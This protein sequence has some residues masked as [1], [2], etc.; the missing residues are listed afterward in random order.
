MPAQC[1]FTLNGKSTWLLSCAG[2]GTVAAFSGNGAYVDKP[3]ATAVPNA[4]PFPKGRY[5]IIKREP[6]GRLGR[7]RDFSLD[8]WSNSDRATWFALYRVDGTIDDWTFVNG[9][10]R[11]NFRLHPNG[12][13]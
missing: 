7:L 3:T 8:M 1:V 9:V 11:G 2:F 13:S 6:G 12:R 5:Y 10:R 4:G